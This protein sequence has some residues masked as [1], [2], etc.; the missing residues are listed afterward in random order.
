M[1]SNLN[2]KYTPTKVCAAA[3]RDVQPEI[4]ERRADRNMRRRRHIGRH[5]YNRAHIRRALFLRQRRRAVRSQAATSVFDRAR[6]TRTCVIFRRATSV[7]GAGR[8]RVCGL[9][10]LV[11]ARRRAEYAADLKHRRQKS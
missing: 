7:Q 3:I 10:R 6:R 2:Q 5:G 4:P 1:K 8:F 11:S 9:Y